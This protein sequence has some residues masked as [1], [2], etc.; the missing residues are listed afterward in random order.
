[1]PWNTQVHQHGHDPGALHGPNCFQGHCLGLGPR[2]GWS[3]HR[4][5]RQ[6]PSEW[7]SVFQSHCSYVGFA[8]QQ[9]PNHYRH[10]IGRSFAVVPRKWAPRGYLDIDQDDLK[11]GDRLGE[12]QGLLLSLG[13]ELANLN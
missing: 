1:M 3:S 7:Y 4:H 11:E 8:N 13:D 2:C 9:H 5:H 10:F 12:W 6:S